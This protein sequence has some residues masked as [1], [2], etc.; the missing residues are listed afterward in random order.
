MAGQTV[1]YTPVLREAG[2]TDN[3]KPIGGISKMF[4]GGAAHGTARVELK[5]HPE[6][7]QIFINGTLN[8]KTTPVTLQFGPG[9]Y[10]V[11]L[12]KEGYQPVTRSFAVN[13]DEKMK[14]EET[15][16]K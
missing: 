12:H 11:R 8:S 1:N 3:I 16:P 2:R 13:G 14:I 7:A 10:D 4:G 5:T 9:N 15:L 6:G